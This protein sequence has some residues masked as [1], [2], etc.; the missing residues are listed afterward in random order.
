ML[1]TKFPVGNGVNAPIEDH[2]KARMESPSLPDSPDN[3]NGTTSGENLSAKWKNGQQD[4][5][6]AGKN[7]YE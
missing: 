7:Q 6:A 3:I 5:P 1:N 4:V 2:T